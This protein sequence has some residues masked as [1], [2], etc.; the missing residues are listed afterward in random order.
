[1]RQFLCSTIAV[2]N[3][4]AL[5]IDL[6]DR[7]PVAVFNVEG[8]FHVTDDTC[9][10]EDASLSMGEIEDGIIECPLHAGCFDLATGKAIEPPAEVPLRT[11]PVTIVDGEIYIEIED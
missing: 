6:E 9:T 8:T 2:P 4:G 7:P 1:M 3:N 5:R 11:Y 10:H